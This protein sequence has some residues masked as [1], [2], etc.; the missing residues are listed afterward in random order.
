LER[1]ERT[2]NT[3]EPR[4][5]AENGFGGVLDVR[6]PLSSGQ[7]VE[8]EYVPQHNPRDFANWL[9]LAKLLAPQDEAAWKKPPK[10]WTN[11]IMRMIQA[12]SAV[13][14]TDEQVRTIQA[15]VADPQT[16]KGVKI[17]YRKFIEYIEDQKA[18]AA[19]A[20][21]PASDEVIVNLDDPAAQLESAIVAAESFGERC[22]VP[23]CYRVE[24]TSVAR[25]N[26]LPQPAFSP[27]RD[28]D[29]NDTVMTLPSGGVEVSLP[30]NVVRKTEGPMVEGG[31]SRTHR[32]R[33]STA[34]RTRR[35][36]YNK[37][38]NK[39]KSRKQLSRKKISRRRQSRRK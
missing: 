12:I 37:K 27:L 29:A 32:R 38:S 3:E 30:E 20:G 23:V 16:P 19:R 24:E 9:L 11:P 5:F 26:T 22:I 28:A 25:S 31:K 1:D 4:F 6:E 15:I 36:A 7:T 33:A 34:K 8:P 14:T 2:A 21:V 39:R 13:P 10:K 35:K 18:L 17:A